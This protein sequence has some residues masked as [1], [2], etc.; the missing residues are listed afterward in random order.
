MTEYTPGPWR[1]GDPQMHI[2]AGNILAGNRLIAN[3]L[4]FA[5]NAIDTTVEENQAN[6]RLIAAAPDL[7]EAAKAV[8]DMLAEYHAER[9]CDGDNCVMWVAIQNAR[10]AIAAAEGVE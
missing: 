3:C 9:R 8:T 2:Q 5:T 1:N 6:A 4:G 10:A 7:Y